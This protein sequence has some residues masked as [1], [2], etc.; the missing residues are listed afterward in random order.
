MQELHGWSILAV[1]LSREET[2]IGVAMCRIRIE[3][4]QPNVAP[5]VQ[6]LM[7][8]SNQISHSCLSPAA[9]LPGRETFFTLK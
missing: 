8:N 2:G 6:G 5:R 9:P 7:L 1:K 4:A 3:V